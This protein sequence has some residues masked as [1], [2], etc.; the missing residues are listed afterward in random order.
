MR[1]HG[2][3][4]EMVP[5]DERDESCLQAFTDLA[6]FVVEGSPQ[7][8]RHNPLS[9]GFQVLS[10]HP[11]VWVSRYVSERGVEQTYGRLTMREY[12]DSEQSWA[13]VRDGVSRQSQVAK[14][15]R[16]VA[17]HRGKPKFQPLRKSCPILTCSLACLLCGPYGSPN[18]R[19]KL[20]A[21]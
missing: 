20:I 17:L 6:L 1:M 21:A 13:A 3:S 18:M 14:V 5:R 19:A 2:V 10:V 12:H 9:L 15:R 7:W 4:I 16:V 8:S 11:L